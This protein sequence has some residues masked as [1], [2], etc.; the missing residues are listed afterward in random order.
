ME[1]PSRLYNWIAIA[2]EHSKMSPCT[3]RKFAA[4]II[5]EDTI[6]SM[7]YNGSCRGSLNCG[8]EIPC[9]KD[10]NNDPSAKDNVYG[11]PYSDNC[12]AVHAEENAIIN[13]ARNGTS[14]LNATLLLAATGGRCLRPCARCRRVIINAGITHCYFIQSHPDGTEEVIHELTKDWVKMENDWMINNLEK[15]KKKTLIEE[16]NDD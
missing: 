2:K 11:I 10:A 9:L 6:I 16:Y 12:P 4:I 1:R 7:G 8:L 15:S 14:T 5:K 13:A 3:R